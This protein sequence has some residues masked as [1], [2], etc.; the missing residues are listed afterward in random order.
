MNARKKCIPAQ[1]PQS[2]KTRMVAMI[3][4]ANMDLKGQSKEHVKVIHYISFYFT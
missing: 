2:V 3:A 1:S 4:R